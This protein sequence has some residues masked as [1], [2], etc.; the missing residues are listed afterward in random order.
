MIC[1]HGSSASKFGL[2]EPKT[3]GRRSKLKILAIV[4]ALNEEASISLAINELKTC[5]LIDSILVIDDGSVDK[6]SELA[7][8]SGVSVLRHE[9]NLGVGAA[10][11]TGFQF[12]RENNFDF[13]LQFDADGQHPVNQ[14]GALV[15]KMGQLD[16]LIGGRVGVNG[17]F[18]PGYPM[19]RPRKIAIRLLSR[20]VS[21][22]IHYPITDSTSGFRL[23]S[24][25]SIKLF[26]ENFPD[27]YLGDTV[28]S[29]LIAHNNG[30]KVGQIGIQMK[31]RKY[32]KPSQSLALSGIRFVEVFL[33]VLKYFVSRSIKI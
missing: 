29:L 31:E 7:I 22:F 27:K 11:R 4:P 14:I 15:A 18:L 19:S 3:P 33:R 13:A 12:A 28:E 2:H 26:S 23:N 6:T 24:R 32:G 16:I 10:L 1:F 21:A 9:S 20:L 17:K 30:L 5:A 25:R 8:H